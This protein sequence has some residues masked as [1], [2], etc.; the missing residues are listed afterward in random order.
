MGKI[1]LVIVLVVII[2]L[3]SIG[4]GLLIF[5]LGGLVDEDLDRLEHNPNRKNHKK[6]G[7]L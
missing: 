6:N 1:I 3:A 5:I 2:I 7:T 4:V